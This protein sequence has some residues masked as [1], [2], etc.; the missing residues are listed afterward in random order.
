MIIPYEA[1]YRC[2]VILE[3]GFALHDGASMWDNGAVL[4][5]PDVSAKECLVEFRLDD[6]E[7][8]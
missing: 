1:K 7:V 6:F 5:L 2:G 4:Y 8:I 3:N